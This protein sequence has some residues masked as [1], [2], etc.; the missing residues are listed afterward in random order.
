MTEACLLPWLLPTC[1]CSGITTHL[2]A[3]PSLLTAVVSY[4][5]TN[6]ACLPCCT[7]TSP[8]LLSEGN[9]LDQR[10]AG[11]YWWSQLGIGQ[12]GG[13][14]GRPTRLVMTV[15]SVVASVGTCSVLAD[16]GCCVGWAQGQQ[17]RLCFLTSR[18]RVCGAFLPV[19]GSRGFRCNVRT[20]VLGQAAVQKA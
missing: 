11:R 2:S 15:S 10:N 16:R 6:V 7:S 3:Q 17:M 9:R 8:N 18:S 12:M 4:S 1:S 13:K 5:V 20:G 19:G 14:T